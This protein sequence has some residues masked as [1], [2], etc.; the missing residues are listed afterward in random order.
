MKF[1]ADK[2]QREVLSALLDKYES[3]KTYK[4]ENRV[5]QS[6]SMT[7][8]VILKEYDSDFADVEK[9]QLFGGKAG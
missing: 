2:T 7:P 9:V 8:D 1:N 5:Q 4:G 6:F 3:S